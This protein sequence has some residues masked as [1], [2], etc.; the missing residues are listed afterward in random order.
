MAKLLEKLMQ[1]LLLFEE[2]KFFMVLF[3]KK[4]VVKLFMVLLNNENA[5][6]YFLVK[7]CLFIKPCNQEQPDEKIKK[8]YRVSVALC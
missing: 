2:V 8:Y 1:P 4:K 7:K 6:K 5:P 3:K